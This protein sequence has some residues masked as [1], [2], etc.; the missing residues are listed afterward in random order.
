MP[1]NSIPFDFGG[2]VIICMGV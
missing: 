1:S 2:S